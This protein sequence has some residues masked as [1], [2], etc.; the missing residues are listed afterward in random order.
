MLAGKSDISFSLRRYYPNQVL[1]V[2]GK[3][4]STS[5]ASQPLR[6]PGVVLDAKRTA[7]TATAGHVGIIEFEA[8]AVETVD[9]INFRTVHIK[10]A[11]LID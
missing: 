2:A 11:C 3:G 7:A 1:G 10:K 4:G 5:Q 9:V 8:G 6:S